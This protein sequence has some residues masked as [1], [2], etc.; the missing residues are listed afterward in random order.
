LPEDL[1][2][3]IDRYAEARVFARSGLLA[4][5]AKKLMAGAA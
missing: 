3:Q 2:E 1:L 5:A 4:Q